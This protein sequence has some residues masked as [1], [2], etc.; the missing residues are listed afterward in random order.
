MKMTSKRRRTRA[1]I[2]R[3]K[4]ETADKEILTVKRLSQLDELE[5]QMVLMQQ[6]LTDAQSIHSRV[7][8]L[9]VQGKLKQEAEVK[10]NIVM[11]PQEQEM[12]RLSQQQE[13]LSQQDM[14]SEEQEVTGQIQ[15]K[16]PQPNVSKKHGNNE[17]EFA[18]YTSAYDTQQ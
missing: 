18:D 12:L 14:D 15:A 10:F 7:N 11:N 6:Q 1:E 2:E 4:K 16:N 9:F 13:Q 3:D 8:E 5:K 17:I